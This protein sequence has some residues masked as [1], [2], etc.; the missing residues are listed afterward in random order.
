MGQRM[1]RKRERDLVATVQRGEALH[2]QYRQLQE[3][4]ERRSSMHERAQRAWDERHERLVAAHVAAMSES[5]LEAYEA[6][7]AHEASAGS[8]TLFRLLPPPPP[9]PPRPPEASSLNAD[10]R[11]LNGAELR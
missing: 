8:H 9:P 4:H 11:Q 10:H 1:F 3:V 5:K 6:V 7:V 2:K